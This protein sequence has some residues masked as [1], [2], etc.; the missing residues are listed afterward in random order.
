MVTFAHL[1]GAERLR[2]DAH[3]GALRARRGGARGAARRDGVTA[4]LV[5]L[6]AGN[7]WGNGVAVEGFQKDPDTDADSRYNDVGPDYFQDA[8]RAAAR[9]PRV[10][11]RP[12]AL[13][14]AEG[15]DRQRGV[16]EEVQP[17]ARRGRQAH[18][19]AATTRS[20]SQIVG[21]VQELEVQRGEGRRSRR[22]SC[23]PYRQDAAVGSHHFY[24][25]TRCRPEQ[26]LRAI[27][28]VIEAARSES[29][30]RGA[31]DDA[32]AGARERL[33]R[34][35]DQRRCRRAF[36]LLATLLAAVGLYGVLAYSVAQRTREIGV[37]MAL[38]AD[39]VARARDGAAAGRRDDAHR[40]RRSASRARSALGRGAQ[41]LLY[42]A[43]GL[44]PGRC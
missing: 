38:G 29:A 22:C 32:A 24:V 17:R 28:T 23:M 9:R 5:P 34:P 4:A 37:R 41:S 40:R 39:A 7:N 36:A 13:G 20:T 30:G 1:A 18:V 21:L 14:A 43:E 8:R 31:Q 42:R 11:A 12:T 44:R 2:P 19:G 33:P 35:H 25:R 6:L 16:R 27:P 26:M 15:R 3:R 10:H